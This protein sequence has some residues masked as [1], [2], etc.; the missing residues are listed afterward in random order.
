MATTV[1]FSNSPPTSASHQ[2]W[3][4]ALVESG[5]SDSASMT[6]N[7]AR[8]RKK[9]TTILRPVSPFEIP[10]PD[11]SIGDKSER[12][13]VENRTAVSSFDK[14]SFDKSNFDKH[15]AELM[16]NGQEIQKSLSL[17]DSKI[18]HLEAMISHLM[19]RFPLPQSPA[20]EAQ[21]SPSL[22]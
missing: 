3:T 19:E 18:G 15:G 11:H 9:S 12:N 6:N 22:V 5:N 8:V 17:L 14:S 1:M 2:R 7:R 13:L 10:S 16:E 21:N 20:F 4:T